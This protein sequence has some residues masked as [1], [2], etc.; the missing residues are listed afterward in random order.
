MLGRVKLLGVAA[1]ALA[2]C[3]GAPPSSESESE[4]APHPRPDAG[5]A[6]AATATDAAPVAPAPA[7]DLAPRLEL[8]FTGDVMF[9]GLFKR[10]FSPQDVPAHDPLAASPTC[11][12]DL[13]IANSRPR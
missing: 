7:P 9:G 11:A 13:P 8:T 6:A 3:A 4:P 2:A 5:A 1:L 12:S 10:K